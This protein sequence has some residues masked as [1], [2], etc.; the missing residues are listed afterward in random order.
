MKEEIVDNDEISNIVNEIQEQDRTIKVLKKDY[1]DKIK[2]L[3][4]ALLNY[5]GE[6]VPKILKTELP[7]KKWKHL[8]KKLAY[9]FEYFKSID[10]HQKPVDNLKE[11][12]FFSK[13]KNKCP[14]DEEVERTEQ[15]IKLFDI[16]HWEEPTQLYLKSDVLLLACVFEKLTK[17]S[18]NE[19][20]INPLYCFPLPGYTWQCGVKYIGINLQTHQE[21]DLI[22]TLE[23]NIRGG[24]STVM[25]VRYVKTDENKKIIFMDATN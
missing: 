21:K 3:E 14:D 24:K 5:M 2:K 16:K 11:E 23:N 10:E 19:F 13:L 22:L 9:P 6:N 25:G 18:I 12:D 15:V 20:G 7:D 8:I 4:E 1:P 17:V